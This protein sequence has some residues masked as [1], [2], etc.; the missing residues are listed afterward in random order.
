MPKTKK[1][2]SSTNL[3]CI[4]DASGTLQ[5]ARLLAEGKPDWKPAECPWTRD[6][7]SKMAFFCGHSCVMFNDALVESAGLVLLECAMPSVRRYIQADLRRGE[8][9]Q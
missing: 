2:T 1:E 8:T 6:A 4:I 5:I 9:P 3:N 7:A